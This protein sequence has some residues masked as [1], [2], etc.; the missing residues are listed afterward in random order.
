MRNYFSQIIHHRQIVYL[1]LL[2]IVLIPTYFIHTQKYPDWGDDFAQ[3]VYQAQQI[4]SPSQQYKQVL[5]VSEYSSPKRSVFFSVALAVLSPTLQIQ[6]YVNLISISYILAAICFF[7]FLTKYFNLIISVL[8]SLCVFYNFLFLRLKSEVVPEFLFI[9]L[10]CLILFLI[11][12]KKKSTQYI[13]PVLLALLFSVRFIGLS[14]LLA[15]VFQILFAKENMMKQKA[16]DVMICLGIFGLVTFCINQFFITNIN[17]QEVKLYGTLVLEGFNFGQF[18]DNVSMYARYIILFF[19]QEIPYWM[20]TI[21]TGLVFS[22]FAIGFVSSVKHKF[23]II[24]LS[25]MFYFLFLFFYPYNGDTIKY[26]IPIVPLLIYFCIYGTYVL[27]D[28]MKLKYKHAFVV[29]SLSVIL[30]SNSKTIYLAINH[31]DSKI[32]PYEISVIQDLEKV[33]KIVSL[34]KTIAFGKPFIINLMCDR[35]SYFVSEKNYKDVLTKA[36]YFLS[37]KSS[38][39]ELYEKHINVHLLK[40]DTISLTHFYLV[41]L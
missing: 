17:N 22:C 6:Q 13:I 18:I 8:G 20:N 32:G 33:K 11:H 28:I 40:G 27:L 25:F 34:E 36:N 14:L 31:Q 1:L 38:V 12:S 16:K 9:A 26:L 19:E 30:L 39:K 7:L 37:P 10:F 29:A 23:G 35:N 24:H 15:Y 41:K 3:Y 4:H 2:I 21:I 5:N